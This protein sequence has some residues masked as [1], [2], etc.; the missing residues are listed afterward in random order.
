VPPEV[1]VVVEGLIVVVVVGGAVVVVGAVP[2]VD[3]PLGGGA[4][5][6]ALVVEV[7]V[8]TGEGAMAALAGFAGA[9]TDH[10]PHLSF[11]TPFTCPGRVSLENQ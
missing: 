7:V 11:T 4:L 3:V 5:M 9:T 8:R 1:V 10:L 6:G 2:V